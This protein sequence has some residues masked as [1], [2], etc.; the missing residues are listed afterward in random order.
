MSNPNADPS[1]APSSGA[2]RAEPPSA[3]MLRYA[4]EYGQTLISFAA[5]FDPKRDVAAMAAL[6]WL[7]T[8]VERLTTRT[9]SAASRNSSESPAPLPGDLAAIDALR[10]RCAVHADRIGL[11]YAVM[12]S[13]PVPEDA[14]L[15]ALL[16][17]FADGALLADRAALEGKYAAQCILTATAQAQFAAQVERIGALEAERDELKRAWDMYAENASVSDGH[18]KDC[19]Y[20][21]LKPCSCGLRELENAIVAMT[22]IGV[23]HPDAEEPR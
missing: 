1:L 12:R 10:S 19:E 15:I 20:N 2:G 22:G 4:I 7:K 18:A 5:D 13:E 14:D 6:E 8:Q 3:S 16:R 9:V 11:D 17:E 21:E 23:M